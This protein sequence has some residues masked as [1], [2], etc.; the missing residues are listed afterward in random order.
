MDLLDR[1][2]RYSE[3]CLTACQGVCY[4]PMLEKI[5]NNPSVGLEWPWPKRVKAKRNSKYCTSFVKKRVTTTIPFVKS[6]VAKNLRSKS[7]APDCESTRFTTKRKSN[8]GDSPRI[9]VVIQIDPRSVDICRLFFYA[10][11]LGCQ[12]VIP[13]AFDHKDSSDAVTLDCQAP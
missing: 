4:N 11:L 12:A 1:W 9:P 6:L 10:Y 5:R 7:I 2:I 8:S 13:S 3:K